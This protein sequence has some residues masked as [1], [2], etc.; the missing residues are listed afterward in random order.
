MAVVHFVKQRD[1]ENPAAK[2]LKA[3]PEGLFREIMKYL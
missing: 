1:L 2:A 3:V